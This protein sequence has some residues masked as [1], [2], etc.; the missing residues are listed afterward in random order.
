MA[1]IPTEPA[2]KIAIE[3]SEEWGMLRVLRTAPAPVCI[4]QPSGAYKAREERGVEGG[5]RTTEERWTR[6]FFENEDWPKKELWR[7]LLSVFSEGDG[8]EDEDVGE[9]GQVTI[10][11]E[12]V[13]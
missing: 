6:V 5:R 8:F 12:G 2:P 13:S 1:A 11:E 9:E 4:P 10:A 7:G 3:V